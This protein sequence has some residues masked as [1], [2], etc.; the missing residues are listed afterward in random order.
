VIH[1]P[2]TAVDARFAEAG[3]DIT[4]VAEV[5]YGQFQTAEY[6]DWLAKSPY[7]R[8]QSSY[9]IH[10]AP[11]DGLADFVSALRGR[12]RYLFVTN[13]SEGCYQSFGDAWEV[14]V[15]AISEGSAERAG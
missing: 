11:V 10:G 2:G 9:M 8:D 6:Q 1:N 15:E 13:L 7:G 5:D 4:T 12:A 3:P 14:F